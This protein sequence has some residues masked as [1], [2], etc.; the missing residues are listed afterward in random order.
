[1]CDT[2]GPVRDVLGGTTVLL[3]EDDEAADDDDAEDET[4]PAVLRDDEDGARRAA[5][6]DRTMGVLPAATGALCED[7]WSCNGGA[8]KASI[9]AINVSSRFATAGR[10]LEAQRMDDDEVGCTQAMFVTKMGNDESAQ[11]RQL[12]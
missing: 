5:G 8:A 3:D 12:T 7:E 2:D 4:R 9:A 10:F 1:M 11:N 6:F